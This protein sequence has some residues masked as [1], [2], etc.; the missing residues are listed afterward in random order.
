MR[1]IALLAFLLLW[2]ATVG[3]STGTL[4]GSAGLSN[5]TS[6]IEAV[7]S[8]ATGFRA[9]QSASELNNANK[10]LVYAQTAIAESQVDSAEAERQRL[11]QER[12][13]TTRLL[14]EM[15][16]DYNDHIYLALAEW[17]EAGGDPD[18]AFKYALSRVDSSGGVKVLPQQSLSFPQPIQTNSTK[19]NLQ[20]RASQH[21][22]SNLSEVQH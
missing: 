1:R 19:V 8:T 16:K 9:V 18:F 5:V 20:Q 12:V 6:A 3:C 2:G 11:T 17:V 21:E 22:A 10:Q 15:S 4:S 13:V 7:G 14:R